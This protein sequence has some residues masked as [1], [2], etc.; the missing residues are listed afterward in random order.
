MPPRPEVSGDPD[1]LH[2]PRADRTSHYGGGVAGKRSG[3]VPEMSSSPP[4]ELGCRRGAA[5]LDP[6]TPG[7][8]GSFSDR[9]R[10]AG[11]DS[12]RRKQAPRPG[13]RDRRIGTI[14]ESAPQ[15]LRIPV[16]PGGFRTS[17]GGRG[18]KRAPP[19]AG[20]AHSGF[21]RHTMP[22]S[23]GTASRILW[24]RRRPVTDDE[25]R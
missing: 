4:S 5:A 7:K 14:S 21:V 13:Q 2:S 1:V 19:P 10:V 9:H 12:F 18:P 22:R 8:P 11:A 6:A 20:S 15:S 16:V 17:R 24:R 3:S 25:S 23:P